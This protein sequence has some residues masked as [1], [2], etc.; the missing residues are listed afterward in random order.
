V[1][2]ADDGVGATKIMAMGAQV[3]AVKLKL[4]LTS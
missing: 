4:M 1:Y 2:P 3:A